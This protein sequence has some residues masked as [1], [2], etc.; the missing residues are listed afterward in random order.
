MVI[1]TLLTYSKT[2]IYYI[3]VLLLVIFGPDL[4]SPVNA[5]IRL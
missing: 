3:V 4:C 2:Y 5:K 1:K